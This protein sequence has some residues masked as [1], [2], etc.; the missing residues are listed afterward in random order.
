VETNLCAQ[1]VTAIPRATLKSPTVIAISVHPHAN[2]IALLK[3]QC[4]SHNHAPVVV[5]ATVTFDGVETIVCVFAIIHTEDKAEV[6]APACTVDPDLGVAIVRAFLAEGVPAISSEG[7]AAYIVQPIGSAGSPIANLSPIS[8][9]PLV[10]SLVRV[11]T[12]GHLQLMAR[13]SA[14]RLQCPAVVTR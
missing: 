1:D 9:H 10:A 3:V 5:T 13:K 12:H 11:E 6:V 7:T 2:V 8:S 14:F 4:T